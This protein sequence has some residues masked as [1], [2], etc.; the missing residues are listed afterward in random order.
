MKD[1][2]QKYGNYDLTIICIL[3]AVGHCIVC[4]KIYSSLSVKV[5]IGYDT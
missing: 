3:C 2:D 1:I 4:E 5:R